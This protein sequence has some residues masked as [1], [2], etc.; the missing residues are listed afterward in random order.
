MVRT[1]GERKK[2]IYLQEKVKREEYAGTFGLDLRFKEDLLIMLGSRLT[3][4]RERRRATISYRV[5]GTGAYDGLATLLHT[6][7]FLGTSFGF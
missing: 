4:T 6:D 1:G 3:Y 7:L 5:T 2:G